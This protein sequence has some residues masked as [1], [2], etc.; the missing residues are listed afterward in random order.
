MQI[1][2]IF[3]SWHRISSW[4]SWWGLVTTPSRSPS[5]C[6]GHHLLHYHRY[7]PPPPRPAPGPRYPQCP[8]WCLRS[9]PSSCTPPAP[10]SSPPSPPPPPPRPGSTS[11]AGSWRLRSGP[12]VWSSWWRSWTSHWS[13]WVSSPT[14]WRSPGTPGTL[15]SKPGHCQDSSVC[16][17]PSEGP[18][19]EDWLLSSDRTSSPPSWWWDL[20]P[21]PYKHY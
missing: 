19:W 4:W 9:C 14:S 5:Q 2:I 1:I 20:Y 17:D 15:R 11:S 12:E 3:S 6:P 13:C 18:V 7:P 8:D 10:S 21:R 16:R